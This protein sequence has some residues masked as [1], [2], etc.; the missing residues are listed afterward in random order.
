MSQTKFTAYSAATG[1]VLSSGT[2]YDWAPL[3][4]P[5]VL[6]LVGEEFVGGWIADDQH[7]PMPAKPNPYNVFNWTTKQWEDPR[8]IESEWGVVRTRRSVLLT[9]SDWVVVKATETAEPVP[10]AWQD[11]R[12]A[13]RDVTLQPDPFNIS[14]PTQP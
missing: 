2:T 11:Y 12:Q 6:V 4:K 8:T 1:K 3:V 5:G 14:W 7:Y 9:A 13:L 10:Q